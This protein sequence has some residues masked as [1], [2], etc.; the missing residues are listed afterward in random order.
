MTILNKDVH[1]RIDK[2]M[3]EVSSVQWKVHQLSIEIFKG[4]KFGDVDY[5][6]INY[7]YSK[8]G[9]GINKQAYKIWIIDHT[10]LVW[11]K[12]EDRFTKPKKSNWNSFNI[13]PMDTTP[14][15]RYDRPTKEGEEVDY[16]EVAKLS[17]FKKRVKT[18]IEEFEEHDIDSNILKEIQTLLSA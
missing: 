11:N 10:P 16:N 4:V 7:L 13:V 14:Y 3:N 5:N 15:Y 6:H 17:A 8:M 18:L 1:A 9:K 2:L 12:E